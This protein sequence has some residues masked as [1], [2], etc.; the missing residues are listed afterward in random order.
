MA[1]IWISPTLKTKA[2]EVIWFVRLSFFRIG[3][4]F[5]EVEAARYAFMMCFS[6]LR[7]LVDL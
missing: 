4:L 5:F 6:V 2:V 1:S 7:R 3:G